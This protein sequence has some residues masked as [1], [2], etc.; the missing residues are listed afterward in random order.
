MQILLRGEGVT[1]LLS[2]PYYPPYNGAIEAGIG[3]IAHRANHHAALASHPGT[4]S[5]DDVEAARRQGNALARPFG[6][7]CPTPDEAWQARKTISPLTRRAFQLSV[8]SA[9][10]DVCAPAPTRPRGPSP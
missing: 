5:M 7:D 10:H 3:Q 6:P 9:F 4:W 2:P 8:E 1:H